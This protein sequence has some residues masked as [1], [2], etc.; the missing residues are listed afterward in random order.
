M[1]RQLCGATITLLAMTVLFGCE[2]SNNSSLGPGEGEDPGFVLDDGSAGDPAFTLTWS[3]DQSDEG[4]D[5]DMWVRDPKGQLLSTSRDGFS[6]GPTPEGGAID[7]DDLGAHGDGTGG[8]PERTYWRAGSAPSGTYT[9][10]VRYYQGEGTADYTLRVYINSKLTDT[11]TGRFSSRGN[12]VQLGQVEIDGNQDLLAMAAT[13]PQKFTFCQDLAYAAV[14]GTP[15][16]K[17]FGKSD[18]GLLY[19]AMT[20]AGYGL[21]Q[22]GFV[23]ASSDGSAEGALSGLKNGDIIMFEFNGPVNNRL[24]AHYAVVHDGGIHQIV[25]WTD[26]SS[27]GQLDGPRPPS[28]FFTQRTLTNPSTGTQYTLRNIYKY[29]KVYRK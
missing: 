25:H 15:P 19:D 17:E 3:H 29:F 24:A 22:E 20:A 12:Q 23:P 21:T 28:F 16:T 26:P 1:N 6:L 4:P 13:H 2:D 5:I 14:H 10:G 11:K 8:G 9:Y 7:R 27:F 18:E